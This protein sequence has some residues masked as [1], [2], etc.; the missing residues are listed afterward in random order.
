M[1]TA[2]SP[3]RSLKESLIACVSPHLAQVAVA[4]VRLQNQ[5]IS[6]ENP[7]ATAKSH[8]HRG[9]W[10]VTRWPCTW[11]KP[12]NSVPLLSLLLTKSNSP[13][14][15]LQNTEGSPHLP[16]VELNP[17]TTTPLSCSVYIEMEL[18]LWRDLIPAGFNTFIFPLTQLNELILVRKCY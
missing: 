5:Q 18:V 2:K 10:S 12:E 16:F 6:G 3:Q 15:R 1:P 11:L 4:A 8:L 14:L 9:F 13:V 17:S 7:E